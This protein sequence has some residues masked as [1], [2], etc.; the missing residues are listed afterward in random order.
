[1]CLNEI[2]N[3]VHDCHIEF[4]AISKILHTHTRSE[5]YFLLM[6]IWNKIR[7]NFESWGLIERQNFD[8]SS[9]GSFLIIVPTYTGIQTVEDYKVWNPWSCNYRWNPPWW[10]E[11]W[12]CKVVQTHLIDQRMSYVPLA[13]W[14]AHGWLPLW[15]QQR[16]DTMEQIRW[17]T[18]SIL[19]CTLGTMPSSSCPDF[20]MLFPYVLCTIR[21]RIGLWLGS[22]SQ[23]NI[24]VH[25]GI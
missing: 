20:P 25:M 1:M 15:C 11:R 3:T 6:C 16:N 8:V 13:P 17:P 24:F 22:R 23:R 19:D 2:T 7:L 10:L 18:I 21:F 4:C 9:E 5:K 12:S 14:T